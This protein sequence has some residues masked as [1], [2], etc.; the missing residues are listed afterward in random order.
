MEMG[1]EDSRKVPT[2]PPSTGFGGSSTP[3]LVCKTVMQTTDRIQTQLP[4]LRIHDPLRK[5]AQ[6][7]LRG[8]E[9]PPDAVEYAF[10]ALAD[11]RPFRNRRRDVALW[12]LQRLP[13]NPED[14]GR[15]AGR[16]SALVE[17]EVVRNRTRGRS[18]RWFLR[19][20]GV[21]AAFLF[22]PV[23]LTFLFSYQVQELM[24]GRAVRVGIGL[25]LAA[26]IISLLSWPLSYPLS[27]TLDGMRCRRTRKAV[28]A[29]GL[30]AVP[31]TV[32]VLARGVAH[33]A[34]KREASDS[35]RTAAAA[36][37]PQHYGVFETEVVVRL[38]RALTIAD[39]SGDEETTIA[40]LNA[41]GKIGDGQALPLVERF[42]S[43]GS[44]RVAPEAQA[45]VPTLRRRAEEARAAATLLR[46]SAS[47]AAEEV[48][49]R[50]A[51]GAGSA[52]QEQLLRA[53]VETD[54]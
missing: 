43:H 37:T 46:P 38:C 34:V 18:A 35:L 24:I 12:L 28:E 20:T 40:I 36:L 27:A 45:A 11:L 22:I 4:W 7:L 16:L 33:S 5:A 14:A 48:L 1:S 2:N 50:A 31:E 23:A 10:E 3:P 30:L 41:L 13:I 51:A 6:A 53:H 9:P 44:Q 21:I 29:L 17:R 32:G 19:T 54:E 42:T 39:K 8:E 25:T 49:L 52:E 26:V 47:G 15:W